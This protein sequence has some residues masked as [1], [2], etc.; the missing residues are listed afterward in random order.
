[1]DNI[2]NKNEIQLA[3]N[4]IQKIRMM[5]KYDKH[6]KNLISRPASVQMEE[7][8]GELVL[9]Y[10]KFDDYDTIYVYRNQ[11]VYSPEFGKSEILMEYE[12]FDKLLEL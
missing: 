7:Q 2:I 5:F 8:E 12:N 11:I 6:L 3:T 10:I 4:V 9:D 1:M